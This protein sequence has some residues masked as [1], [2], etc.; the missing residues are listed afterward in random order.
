MKHVKE[1]NEIIEK[2]NE[3]LDIFYTKFNAGYVALI[4]VGI[5]LIS[6]I[7]A[8]ILYTNVDPTFNIFSNWIS[9]LGRGPNFSGLAF[10]SGM[11]LS[12]FTMLFFQLYLVRDLQKRGSDK[13]LIKLSYISGLCSSIGL[14]FVGVFPLNFSSILHGIAA[15]TYFFGGLFGCLIYGILELKTPNMSKFQAF[16][17]FLTASVYMT[18]II[19]AIGALIWPGFTQTIIYFTEWLT[20][21]FGTLWVLAHGLYTI[22][23][24]TTGFHK[25]IMALRKIIRWKR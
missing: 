25:I 11:I 8:Y 22:M 21:M 9:D 6:I 12:S 7:S 24:S 23:I 15:D 5:T 16:I 2:Y 10:N 18:Y 20:L 3:K 1:V 4:G 17:G 14:F 19:I 13:T